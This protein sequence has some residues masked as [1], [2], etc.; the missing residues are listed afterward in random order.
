MSRLSFGF[1]LLALTSLPVCAEEF[2][3]TYN[4]N[5][6]PVLH[7]ETDDASVRLRSCDCKQVEAHVYIQGY[8][9]D[10][11]R[12]TENQSGDQINFA[13]RTRD[14]HVN[15]NLGTSHRSIR[16]EVTVPQQSN[17]DVHT[18]DGRIDAENIQGDI[19]L[20]TSDGRI[21]AAHLKGKLELHTSDGHIELSDADG[22]L[23]A[24][25]SDGHIRAL[26]RF[27]DLNLETSDG[28]IFAEVRAGS[29]MSSSWNVRSQDGRVTLRLPQEFSAELYARSGDG[30]IHSDL[31][32]TMEAYSSNR[33]EVRGRLNGGGSTLTVRTNDGSIYLERL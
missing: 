4:V 11:V 27:D 20:N 33:H 24:R 19:R 31:P 18:S 28:E 7:L 17:L 10:Q 15:I 6:A 22:Q 5:G 9:P 23:D 14:R 29:K 13:V 26:G 21:Q 12:M 3:K 8:K 16:I 2:N 1:L 32:I 25:T 30:T